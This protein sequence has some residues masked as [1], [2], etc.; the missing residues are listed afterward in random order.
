MNKLYQKRIIAFMWEKD[1][2]LKELGVKANYMCKEIEKDILKWEDK[3]A[4]KV[5]NE[6]KESIIIWLDSGMSGNLCPYCVSTEFYCNICFYKKINKRCD[7]E[8]NNTF[9]VIC[10][11]ID[12]L[13]ED[14]RMYPDSKFYKQTIKKIEKE[15]K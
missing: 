15:I 5:Y 10:N 7:I 14:Y 4:E 2:K 8:S 11:E 13:G 9:E 3:D 1:R 6:I 12:N